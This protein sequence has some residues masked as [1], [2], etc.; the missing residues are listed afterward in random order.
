ML[1][2]PAATAEEGAVFAPL[3]LAEQ[4]EQDFLAAREGLMTQL[5]E[6]SPPED[7]ARA[8]VLLG[9]AELHLAW[10]MRPEAAGFLE[11]L[12]DETLTGDAAR[13]HRTLSLAL[14]L[15][16][17]GA[18][19][20]LGQAV[21]W[22]VGWGQGQALR[23]AAFARL[24]AVEEAARL[25]P[26]TLESL[27]D[28]P[29]A[30][31]AA[32]LPDLLEAALEAEDWE[33]AQALAAQ[34]PDHAELRDGPAYRYLLARASEVSG[35]LLMAFEGYVQA[36]Q[37]R[38]A[39]AQR[40]R[41]AL[42]RMGRE[43]ETL[44][45]QDALS[46]LKTARWMWSG[47]A[48][49]REG[50]Q[51]LAEVAAEQGDTDTALWALHNLLR[52]APEEEAGGLRVQ[53][54]AIYGAFY[55][56]GA[57]GEIDLG[58]FLEGHTRVSARWRFDPGFVGHAM[59]VPQR[60]LDTGMTA[61]AAREYRAL[62]EMA[63][64][65]ERGGATAPDASLMARLRR[66]EARALL[67]GG[68][69]DAAVDLLSGYADDQGAEA[70][71]LL[72]EAL[73]QAGRSDELAAL[74]LRAQDM[75]LRRSRAVALYE[76]GK[77]GAARQAYLEMWEAHPQ[78]FAFADATR[79][80]LAAYQAGDS[81][82]VSRAAT[83]FPALADLPGWA[84]IATGLGARPAEEGQLG[85]DVMRLSMESADRILDAV[86]KVTDVKESQ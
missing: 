19:G 66:G 17:E 16:D 46:L 67:A 77:W 85:S 9:L 11:A 56:A 42:V 43:T 5:A 4:G 60:L 48:L 32:V 50:A 83:A 33:V 6:V 64:T 49:G 45:G 34:F 74:R 84:E 70:E 65:L 81:A 78:Q 35:D 71:A 21:S 8:E 30:I 62:R 73:A 31:Q 3:T 72:V 75:D 23:A 82:T 79:L 80:T 59:A 29:P 44:L 53:A 10:M 24:G 22:S 54:R 1:L 47:D 69:A 7:P 61:L 36:A 2:A 38:D 86:T 12:D 58:P 41:L 26:R 39:Y 51:L 76:T 63:Q 18:G 52:T 14:A 25:M 28:L 20:D 27:A 40:A 13:R 15:L 57:A 37:G 55:A 68:Q